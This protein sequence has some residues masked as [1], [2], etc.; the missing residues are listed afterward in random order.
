MAQQDKMAVEQNCLR[1]Y[2]NLPGAW[3]LALGSAVGWG[4]FM[5]P[6]TTFL[7]QAGPLGTVI[8]LLL[9]ALVMLVIGFNYHFM[10]RHY[11]DAGGLY[12]YLKNVFNYDHAF[13]GSWFLLLTYAAIIWANATAMALISRFLF[14]DFFRFGFHYKVVG[15]DVYFGEVLLS[16]VFLISLAFICMRARPA[17]YLLIIL[18]VI[19]CFGTAASSFSVFGR[20]DLAAAMSPQFSDRHGVVGGILTIVAMAP[21]AFVGYEAISH[22]ARELTFSTKKYIGVTAAALVTATAVY[23]VLALFA[24]AATPEGYANWQEYTSNLGSFSGKEGVPV[25]YAISTSAGK[26]GTVLLTAMV[27]AAVLTGIVGNY[28]T[29]SRLLYSLSRDGLMPKA[30]GNLNANGV[31]KN[32]LLFTMAVSLVFP[33]LGRTATSWVVDVTTI[34]SAIAYAYV[35]AAATK[36]AR[37]EENRLALVT[38]IVG[39][40]VSC[41]FILS[42]LLPNILAVTALS[43]EAYFILAAWSMVGLLYFRFVFGKDT[44]RRLGRST[45][46]LMTLM[47]IIFFTTTVWTRQSSQRATENVASN[48]QQHYAEE[49][50]AD[51]VVRTQEEYDATH[52]YI[53]WETEKADTTIRRNGIVQ[54]IIVIISMFIMF[55]VYSVIHK[56]ER[57][58]E[59]DKILA[60]QVSRAKTSFLS[61]MSHEIRT[62]MNAIIGLDNIALQN[63]DLA[64]KTKEQLEKIGA[65]ARHLLSLINDILDMSRIESGRM[66]LKNDEFSFSDLLD[67]LSVMISGQCQD[68]GLIYECQIIGHIDPYYVGDEM[69]LRQVLINILGNAVKFTNSPGTVTLIVEQTAEFQNFRSLRFIVKD[70]GIGMDKEYIPKIFE[71]FSQEDA[72]TTN[73]YGGS[74][75]GMAITKNIVEM[76]NGDIS[77]ESE[78]GVGTTFTINVTL[79]ASDRLIADETV[80][81]IPSNMRVLIVDDEPVTCEHSEIV[82]KELNMDAESCLDSEDAYERIKKQIDEGT[83]YQMIFTDMRMPGMN[84][85]EL[86]K[87]IRKLDNGKTIIVLL[88]GYNWDDFADDVW[89]AGVDTV[90]VKPLLAVNVSRELPLI[91]RKKE[92]STGSFAEEDAG[93]G[94]AATADTV[95]LKGRHVLIAED[96]EQNAAILLDLLELEGV[97]ADRA[98]NGQLAVDM[99]AE[100]SVNAYDAILMDVRM[101]LMDGLTA[102]RSIRK[103]DRPDAKSIPI[104]AMTANAFDEDVQN[105]LQ[106]GMNAHLSKPVEPDNLYEALRLLIGRREAQETEGQ[107]AEGQEA[108]GHK[109]EGQEAEGHKEEGQEAEGQEAEGQEEEDQ[110]AEGQ[111]AEGREAVG[112]KE[113]GQEAEDQEEEDQ[114]AEGREAVGHK[115]DDGRS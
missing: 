54:T 38:G 68:K 98:V 51:G 91:I 48:L 70:T 90:M 99:F 49:L 80:G 113:E 71:A 81:R 77:V 66:V 50:V 102:T 92:G 47:F 69:K 103:L 15:Y 37:R 75:L 93:A 33:F 9:G 26:H 10:V 78:K 101:P 7:P 67:P 22:S 8:G 21:W 83:P 79:T 97:T 89:K 18:C 45:V 34:G 14:N 112:H 74:G 41:M 86:T 59:M 17:M 36:L 82:L 13:M 40:V 111:E 100:S 108:E 20:F 23:T 6:G 58:M 60:E 30:F 2:M 106:A 64:P 53:L 39:F 109:E 42:Y 52:D 76:L 87:K 114:K 44:E 32:A 31:P 88:T 72:K 19:L 43:I 63:P 95:S 57:Q 1:N 11:P 61:N 28:I 104:I 4:A 27:F 25:F 5:M 12:S 107:E 29:V 56:R 24:A 110:K 94:D 55:D 35:S 65:S 3:A 62:P 115:A 85:L 16:S 73:R 46:V 96:V 105:S 84:G